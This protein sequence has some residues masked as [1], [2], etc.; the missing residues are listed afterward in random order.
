MLLSPAVRN[1]IAKIA[2]VT[3]YIHQIGASIDVTRVRTDNT[4]SNLQESRMWSREIL[5][6]ETTPVTD[7]IIRC[8]SDVASSVVVFEAIS[9]NLA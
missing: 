3:D 4:R 1:V 8:L 7:C 9:R 2:V 6:G 5:K